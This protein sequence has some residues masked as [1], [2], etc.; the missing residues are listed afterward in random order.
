METRG[1]VERIRT[2][3][4]ADGRQIRIQAKDEDGDAY[5]LSGFSSA[6]LSMRKDGTYKISRLACVIEAGTDG[7]LHFTPT[8]AQLDTK[9]VHDAQIRLV[10][11]VDAVDFLE[12]FQIEVVEVVDDEV[13]EE[14]PEA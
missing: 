1:W 12:P 3:V 7:Y 9:G 2:Y 4:G 14:E 11:G 13:V 5:D 10:S 6:T 8:A